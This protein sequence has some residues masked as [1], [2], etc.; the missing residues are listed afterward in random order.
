MPDAIFADPRLA[1]I[2]DALDTPRHD[3]EAYLAIVEE[4]GARSVL[5][6]GCG[7]GIF[8]CLLAER[9]LTVTGIDPAAAS[10]AS[11]REKPHA[12]KVTWLLGTTNALP[13]L[14]VDLVTMTGNVAQVFLA[15]EDW[16]STLKASRGVLSPS[17]VLVFET[18][19]PSWRAW[20]EWK[21]EQ[22]YRRIEIVGVGVVETWVE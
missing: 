21:R 11:A 3:L 5:D 19:D 13:P 16:S 12:D 14:R 15:D 9:G 1:A 10:L 2:Y 18:R 6:V 4:F 17:G 22:S 8:A 20:E 7:T